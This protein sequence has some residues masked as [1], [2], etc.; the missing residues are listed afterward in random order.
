MVPGRCRERVGMT[1]VSVIQGYLRRGASVTADDDAMI[2]LEGFY[3]V[4]R[5]V[6]VI[7]AGR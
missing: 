7:M 1:G 5:L 6:G 3:V 4:R 2:S